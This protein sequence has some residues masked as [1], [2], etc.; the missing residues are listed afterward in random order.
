MFGAESV[1]V[2]VTMAVI[3]EYEEEEA[4][5]IPVSKAPAEVQ[6]VVLDRGTVTP[7]SQQPTQLSDRQHDEVLTALLKEHKLQP[8]DLLT[9][10]IE[11]LFRE[12]DLSLQDGVETRVTDLVSAAKRR[13]SDYE[14]EDTAPEKVAKIEEIP[15]KSSERSSKIQELPDKSVRSAKIQELP[16]KPQPSKIT[17]LP[18][19][20]PQSAKSVVN[21]VTANKNVEEV[22]LATT[23]VKK[24]EPVAQKAKEASAG[25]ESEEDVAKEAEDIDGKGLSTFQYIPFIFFVL[26]LLS[27]RRH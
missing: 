20:A 23:P 11:F 26:Y 22:K 19:N 7:T 25:D 4:K 10:V 5:Q 17:E 8:L 2:V 24:E 1:K 21:E 9:T 14:G 16:D 12:T 3:S 13:R 15:Q 6:E 18:E 27:R